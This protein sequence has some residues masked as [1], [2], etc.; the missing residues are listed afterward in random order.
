MMMD[1]GLQFTK[2]NLT[3]FID[4]GSD[5][6]LALVFSAEHQVSETQFDFSSIV[7]YTAMARD[8]GYGHVYLMSPI[9]SPS[10][11]PDDWFLKNGKGTRSNQWGMTHWKITSYWN[12]TAEAYQKDYNAALRMAVEP[13]GG[14]AITALGSCGESFWPM[15]G[16][17]YYDDYALA[18]WNDSGIADQHE[19]WKQERMRILKERLSWTADKWLLMNEYCEQ[20]HAK[21]VGVDDIIDDLLTIEPRPPRIMFHFFLE[22]LR[23]EL[24]DRALA[25]D[26]FHN[27]RVW[28]G[29]EGAGGLVEHSHWFRDNDVPVEGLVC[30]PTLLYEKVI[31]QNTYTQIK[32]ATAI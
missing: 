19:W 11:M 1:Y 27:Y 31:D 28:V 25:H 5:S 22:K 32:L 4:S 21:G 6:L 12:P 10:W 15:Y 7:D 20:K 13:V 9:G 29:A 8:A 26:H 17:W 3:H 2:E 24:M 16:P 14:T 18:A 30:G 23:A